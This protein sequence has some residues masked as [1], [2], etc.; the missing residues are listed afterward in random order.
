MPFTCVCKQII[1]NF[2]PVG[3]RAPEF[4]DLRC[5][6]LSGIARSWQLWYQ[7][8]T[9][10]DFSTCKR[11]IKY[12]TWWY[13]CAAFLGRFGD[14]LLGIVSFLAQTPWN[15]ASRNTNSTSKIYQRLQFNT[16]HWSD[17]T[18]R[19]AIFLQDHVESPLEGWRQNSQR[20]CRMLTCEEIF[21][22]C[23]ASR[24]LKRPIRVKTT[25]HPRQGTFHRVWPEKHFRARE[26]EQLRK[27]THYPRLQTEPDE[28]LVVGK[29]ISTSKTDTAQTNHEKSD[30]FG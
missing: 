29:R 1:A 19:R 23:C 14:L 25:A 18:S 30:T 26:L 9:L 16:P 6:R 20:Q 8:S 24:I 27:R 28:F 3:M 5:G 2:P 12:R 21:I 11:A 10:P 13:F 4:I 22:A 17:C 15:N 7:W